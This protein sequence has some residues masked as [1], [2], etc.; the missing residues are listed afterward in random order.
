MTRLGR[1]VDRVTAAFR[2]ATGRAPAGV[3]AAPGRVNLIGEHTDYNDGFVLPVAIDR[4]VVAAAG[5]RTDDRLRLR[6]LQEPEPA[7]LRLADLGPGEVGGWAAYPAG[8]AW[9]LAKQGVPVGGVELVVDGDVPRA[10]AC[11]P[12]P[13]LSV[14]SGWRLPS[15]TTCPWCRPRWRWPPSGPSS[16]PS[17]SRSA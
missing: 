17:A 16:R 5:R 13:P 8:V 3:W 1:Q 6:S 14:R 11:R 7:E 2:E 4:Q 12:A 10:R 15:S 9:V